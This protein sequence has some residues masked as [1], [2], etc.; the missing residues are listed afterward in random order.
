MFAV[1][2]YAHANRTMSHVL[3]YTCAYYCRYYFIYLRR[4]DKPYVLCSI[5]IIYIIYGYFNAHALRPYNDDG[6]IRGLFTG[7]F[8]LAV[9]FSSS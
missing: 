4:E 6:C 3:W 7:D 8:L 1:C 5:R 2:V 9:S